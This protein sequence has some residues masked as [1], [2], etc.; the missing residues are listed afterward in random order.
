MRGLRLSASAIAI[1]AAAAAAGEGTLNVYNW[2]DYIAMD[3]VAKFEALTGIK[4]NYDVYDS[5]EI[6][7][8]KLLAGHSGYDVVV[9][10]SDY[11]QRLLPAGI[12]QPLDKTRL[13]NLANMDPMLMQ[14]AEA[15]DPGNL[16]SVIYMWGTTGIGYNVDLVRDRLGA[17]APVGS[18]DLLF[19]P[20]AVAKLGDCGVVM[21]DSPVE[22]LP[23]AM[24]YAGA[25]PESLDPDAFAKGFDALR[26]IRPHIRYFHSSQLIN[27][28]ANGDICL[29][30]G[31]SGD[32]IQ[33][34]DRAAEAGNG[35][36]IEYVIPKEGAQLWF[37]LMAVP[38][39]APNPDAAHEFINFI[40]EPRITADITNYVAY[41]NANAAAYEF[42]DEDILASPGIYP[43]EEAKQRLWSTVA[44]GPELTRLL[45]RFWAEYKAGT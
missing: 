9:P 44:Y 25:D 6:L 8:A 3:T 21:L 40:M 32:I 20:A 15:Y 37:D 23:S 18:W 13:P 43:S 12:Y 30:L 4:V 31:F 42:V 16:H 45:T 34:Q 11:V 19:D 10:T 26:A 22:V 7:E 36:R 2:S 29:A 27:D 41:A 33:A 17:D 14:V 24:N 28:L 1:A 38:A 39:D 5:N 35:V